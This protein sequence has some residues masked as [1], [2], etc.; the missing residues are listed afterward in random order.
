[1]EQSQRPTSVTA[2]FLLPKLWRRIY[3]WQID[4]C[5]CQSARGQRWL[6]ATVRRKAA[7]R[8]CK[9]CCCATS[10]AILRS[11]CMRN[12]CCITH[13]IAQHHLPR[14]IM[15]IPAHSLHKLYLQQFGFQLS[16]LL[17]V[18]IDVVWSCC[19]VDAC[20]SGHVRSM[21]ISFGPATGA[22]QDLRVS[23]DSVS[24]KHDRRCTMSTR[25]HAQTAPEQSNECRNLA[26][27]A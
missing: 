13:L 6:A 9:V 4:V 24:H 3:Q 10:P 20:L 26:V 14:T 8:P 17:R 16:K 12:T 1:M 18:R 23:F 21:Y 19:Q 27:Q 2:W 11:I 15:F 5:T 7:A 25:K 22:I